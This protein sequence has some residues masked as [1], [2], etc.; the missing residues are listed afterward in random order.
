MLAPG[1]E[2][3]RELGLGTGTGKDWEPWPIVVLYGQPLSL[4]LSLYIPDQEPQIQHVKLS[5]S[6][7]RI[8]SISYICCALDFFFCKSNDMPEDYHGTAHFEVHLTLEICA[9]KNSILDNNV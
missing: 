7:I 3:A 1:G 2:G 8:T 9:D 5:S 6:A 4:S